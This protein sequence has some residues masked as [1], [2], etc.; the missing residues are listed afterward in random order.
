MVTA[1]LEM[2]L[3]VAGVGQLAIALTSLAI[4]RALGWRAELAALRPLTRQVF[5]TYAAYI[6]SF[7]IA[8][9]I[10]SLLAA[11]Q[12]VA[13]TPLAAPIVGF[14]ALY[15]AAR[16]GVQ[17]FYYDLTALHASSRDRA[18]ELVATAAF[19][20]LAIVYTVAFLA[21]IGAVRL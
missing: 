7:N 16:V 1:V 18:A 12:L 2:L 11:D 15:W 13:R 4:P 14:I 5:W 17:L 20:A 19:G 3:R 10:L 21:D 9:G 8:F 6:F